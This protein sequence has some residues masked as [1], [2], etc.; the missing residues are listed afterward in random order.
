MKIKK[1]YFF[2]II[3]L[4]FYNFNAFGNEVKIISKKSPRIVGGFEAEKGAWPWM[5]FLIKQGDEISNCDEFCGGSLIHSKWVVTAGHCTKDINGE[6]DVVLGLHDLNS[7]TGERIHVERIEI[8]ENYD[9]YFLY[10]DIALLELAHE[11]SYTPISIN[12]SSDSLESYTSTVI[13]W[14]NLVSSGLSYPEKLQQVSIPIIDNQTCVESYS[15]EEINDGMLCAGFKAGG[16]DACSGDSGGPLMIFHNNNWLLAGIVSWGKGCAEP[17]Y[18]GVYTRVSK[19]VNFIGE[20]ISYEIVGKITA[21]NKAVANVKIT[22]KGTNYETISD[23]NGDFYFD[24]PCGIYN[25]LIQ[26][27]D[28]LPVNQTVILTQNIQL[29]IQLSKILGD[30]NKDGLINQ[31]DVILLQKKIAGF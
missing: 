13:G 22:F 29:N 12:T 4:F 31:N 6:K 17:E 26:T 30:I 27:Q 15:Q 19:F 7:D 11:S 14:G 16:L 25:L 18:Y 3:F 23:E 1:I 20:Y 28:F 9:D 2:L 24:M 5:V 21:D 8:H 10:S